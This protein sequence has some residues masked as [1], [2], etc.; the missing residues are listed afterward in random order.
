ML[1]Q[2]CFC[3]QVALTV[4]VESITFAII[5]IE[6]QVNTAKTYSEKKHKKTTTTRRYF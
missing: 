4:N 6:T 3:V 1:N 2:Q 5:F